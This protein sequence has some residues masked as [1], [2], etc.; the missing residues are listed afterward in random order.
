M[1]ALAKFSYSEQVKT[2][3]IQAL[4]TEENPSVQVA[5]IEILGQ[6]QEKKAIEPLKRLLEK[7]ET[8]PFIKKEINN[9]L[10]KII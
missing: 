5:L 1:E 3:F 8:Q 2:L 6:L 7:E 4:E 9:A 10:P